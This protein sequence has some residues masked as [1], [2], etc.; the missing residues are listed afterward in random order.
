MSCLL[1]LLSLLS[2]FSLSLS[3]SLS[4][5]SSLQASLH[6]LVSGEESPSMQD[7][8]VDLCQRKAV[9]YQLMPPVNISGSYNLSGVE[10][11]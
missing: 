10:E 9:T 5:L 3:L 6:H 8:P 11:R 1:S 2:P 4:P 7:C